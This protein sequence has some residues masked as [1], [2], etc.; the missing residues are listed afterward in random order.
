[1][2]CGEQNDIVHTSPGEQRLTITIDPT[3]GKC[4]A[5]ERRGCENIRKNTIPVLSC[6]GACIRGEIARTAANL[7][8]KKEG[9]SRGCH[10][11]LLTVPDSAIAQWIKT[12]D[13]V[14]VIDGCFLKCHARI[15]KN[16]LDHS[17]IAAFDALSYYGKFTEH[18]DADAVPASEVKAVAAS[19][20]EK[21]LADLAGADCGREA[22]ALS[23]KVNSV[24]AGN[25]LTVRCLEKDEP[26]GQ[27]GSKEACGC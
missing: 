13:R 8:S 20:A 9:Y 24:P 10:G 27:N 19:V 2:G 5:G 15:V 6:E 7:L 1:M 14:V 26:A 23:V 25:V 17:K 16:L 4:L 21:I 12:A 3:T 11:E 18:F 22:V